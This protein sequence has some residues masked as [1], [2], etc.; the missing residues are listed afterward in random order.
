[1]LLLSRSFRRKAL[2]T[3]L[4]MMVF[5]LLYEATVIDSRT[6]SP[7]G[8]QA[9]APPANGVRMAF[10]A[11]AYCK[12]ETTASG[13][14]VRAGMVAADPKVLPIG[15]VIQIDGVADPYKGIYTV[16]DTGPAIQGRIVDLY[17]WSCYEALDFGRRLVHVTVLRRG[18]AAPSRR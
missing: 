6:V 5:T 14:R 15:S 1:M 13:I 17:M 11:T 3:M 16:L 10:Q 7:G 4:T 18:W 2:A 9:T 12:G 8:T